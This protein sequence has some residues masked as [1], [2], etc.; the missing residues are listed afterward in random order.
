MLFPTFGNRPGHDDLATC[1]CLLGW[2]VEAK[3]LYCPP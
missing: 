3:Y 2:E 1:Q